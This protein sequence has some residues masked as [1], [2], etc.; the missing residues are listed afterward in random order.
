MESAG[1][2]GSPITAHGATMTP[3]ELDE[4]MTIDMTNLMA[5][6]TDQL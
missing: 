5:S 3:D 1:L 4:E 6:R 2:N